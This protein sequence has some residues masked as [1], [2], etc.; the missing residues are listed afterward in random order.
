MGAELVGSIRKS[1]ERP[2]TV[3][4]LREVGRVIQRD[5]GPT[6]ITA[7]QELQTAKKDAVDAST[8]RAADADEGA[9]SLKATEVLMLYRRLKMI[10]QRSAEAYKTTLETE[11]ERNELHDDACDCLLYTS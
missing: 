6:C 5:H 8:K 10:Q 3:D 2:T 4:C 1:I 11:K 9:V 7:V